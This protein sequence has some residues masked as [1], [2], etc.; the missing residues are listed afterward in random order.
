[1]IRLVYSG[2]AITSSRGEDIGPRLAAF[3]EHALANGCTG[4]LILMGQDFL[5]VLEGPDDVVDTHYCH[6]L[7]HPANYQV[8]LLARE[9]IAR[10]LFNE[11]SLGVIPSS[12]QTVNDLLPSP[13][14]PADPGSVRALRL[15]EE[16][17]AGKWHHHGTMGDNPLVVHRR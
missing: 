17:V 11:W 4:V 8:T 6:M 10:H 5:Q 9:A 1:M 13:G 2:S 7:S 12:P 15:I 16:F 3:R 14:S